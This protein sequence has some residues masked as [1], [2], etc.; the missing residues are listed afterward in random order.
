MSIFS[1]RAIEDTQRFG[2]ALL[3]Y[4]SEND[5][6][7]TRSHQSGYYLPKEAWRMLTPQ[8]P[9]SGTNYDHLV[10]V[11]WP[12]G[13]TTNSCV[14]WY[15]TGTRSE[16]RLTRFGRNFNW[17]E[18]EFVGALLILIPEDINHFRAYI[19]D[20]DE[21]IDEVIENLGIN[22]LN[23]W[24]IYPE[25]NEE[26]E[27]N[28]DI[29]INRNFRIWVQALNALP[30]GENFSNFTFDVMERCIPN[31]STKIVDEKV[32]LLLE[33]E[34]KLYRLAERKVFQNQINRL[35]RDIDDF[36][37]TANS[38]LQAR[39]SRAG[40]SFENQI[41]QILRENR[42]EYAIRPIVDQTRPDILIPN[43]QSYYDETF[44]AENKYSIG[45]K[46]TCKDR[47][48]QVL[49]ESPKIPRK[50]IITIQQGISAHQLEEMDRSG[51]TLVVPQQFHTLYPIVHRRNILSISDLINE[52]V[53]K[54][55]P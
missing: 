53:R 19:L 32:T 21:E 2:K 35:Y 40:R 49:N 48:R 20:T 39:K 3:K 22:Y 13:Q 1:Q 34:F 28:E 50:H 36:L 6:G 38:I 45:I 31:F 8:A 24:T 9:Q 25:I 23:T 10:S 16:Y 5:L 47:W 46:R 11:L 52:I 54:Q 7:L 26:D 43:I 29:C 27:I 55:N 44:P 30:S 42:I 17:R 18:P 14:K 41:S 12:D 51:V 4:I 33:N 15:G 37:S